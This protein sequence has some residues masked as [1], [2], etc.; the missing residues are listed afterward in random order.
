MHIAHMQQHGNDFC[1]SACRANEA[2]YENK[3]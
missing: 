1:L 3:L 2:L